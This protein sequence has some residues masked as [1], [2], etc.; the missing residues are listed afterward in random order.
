MQVQNGAFFKQMVLSTPDSHAEYIK[1]FQF[2]W[3]YFYKLKVNEITLSNPPEDGSSIEYKLI[4]V[5]S[6]IKTP[7]DYQFKLG[8]YR[9]LYLGPG[10][11]QVNNFKEINDSTFLYFEKFELEIP[12]QFREGFNKIKNDGI[13]GSGQFLFLSEK[14]IRLIKLN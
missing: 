3:G 4:E 6:K 7:A 5:V 2:E 9:D 10:D 12:A 14:K 11:D 13:D 1:G 8:L